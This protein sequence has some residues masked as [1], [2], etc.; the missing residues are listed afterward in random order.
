[1]TRTAP[2]TTRL[3][4]G[5]ALS[6]AFALPAAAQATPPAEPAIT[7]VDIYSEADAQAALDARLI[8]LKTVI[9]LKPDQEKLWTPVEAALR[10]AAKNANDRAVARAK[11]E[12]AQNFLDVLERVADAEAARAADLKSVISAAKPLVAALS[13]EQKRRIPAFLGMTDI[14][15]KPQPTLELWIFEAEQE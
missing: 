14:P 2:L 6:L 12:P 3:L 15:G 10:Q 5:A 8:A 13:E 7:M 1:M 4:A 9:G 11:A